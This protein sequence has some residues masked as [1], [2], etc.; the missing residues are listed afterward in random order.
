V[1]STMRSI[2]CAR[3]WF[4]KEVMAIVEIIAHEEEL[5]PVNLTI[6]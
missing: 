3:D 4:S 1:R 2:H 6:A 5:L